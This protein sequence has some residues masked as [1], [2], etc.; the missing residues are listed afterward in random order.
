M[1][2]FKYPLQR[3]PCIPII[4][5]VK[6][7]CPRWEVV[8]GLGNFTPKGFFFKKGIL[9]SHVLLGSFRC[10]EKNI[11]NK[12]SCGYVNVGSN[13]TGS[14]FP[15]P[16]ENSLPNDFKYSHSGVYYFT[17]LRKLYGWEKREYAWDPLSSSLMHSHFSK[18]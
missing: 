14:S 9:G 18:E 6:L 10:T 3:L 13:Y 17:R 5:M 16:K 2:V 1:N 12:N 15:E 4:E 11:Q 8:S 7:S